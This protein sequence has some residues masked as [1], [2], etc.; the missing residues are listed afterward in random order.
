MTV[1]LPIGEYHTYEIKDLVTILPIV[2]MAVLIVNAI[3]KFGG[4]SKS[5]NFKFCIWFHKWL[6]YKVG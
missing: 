2:F 4:T 3:E 6:N 1:R 5:R